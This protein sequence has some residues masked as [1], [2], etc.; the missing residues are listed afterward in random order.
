MPEDTP[1]HTP[2][3]WE[4]TWAASE[5][6]GMYFLHEARDSLGVE[7]HDSNARLIAAAP[8]LLE[9]LDMMTNIVSNGEMP[10]NL[11]I[12]QARTAIAKATIEA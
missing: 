8:E 10:R 12:K 2:G 4:V 3:P 5:S 11:V 6:R 9:A 1:K 7:I